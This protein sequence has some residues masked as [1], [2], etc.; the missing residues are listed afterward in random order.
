MQAV[1]KAQ[2]TVHD[3][4]CSELLK[5]MRGYIYI[6][7]YLINVLKEFVSDNYNKIIQQS[8]NLTHYSNVALLT[9][10]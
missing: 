3:Q 7:F 4:R 8:K 9:G 6:Y 5:Y 1:Y 10:I 2:N